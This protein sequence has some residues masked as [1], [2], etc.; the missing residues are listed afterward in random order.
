MRKN[1]RDFQK[2]DTL[3]ARI[4][5][6]EEEV[7]V[8]ALSMFRGSE[9]ETLVAPMIPEHL[10]VVRRGGETNRTQRTRTRRHPRGARR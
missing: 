5:N 9:G 4:Q 3:G 10:D 7:W 2:G 6:D 1:D 8:Y